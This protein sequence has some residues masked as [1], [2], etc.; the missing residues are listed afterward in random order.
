MGIYL[1][2]KTSY[3]SKSSSSCVP[4]F[5]SFGNYFP[6]GSLVLF[7][8]QI[9]SAQEPDMDSCHERVYAGW[10]CRDEVLLVNVCKSSLPCCSFSEEPHYSCWPGEERG[11]FL[12]TIPFSESGLVL[13]CLGLFWLFYLPQTLLEVDPP[14]HLIQALSKSSSQHCVKIGLPSR[15]LTPIF[16]SSPLLTPTSSS[17]H[18]RWCN[19]LPHSSWAACF[20]FMIKFSSGPKSASFLPVISVKIIW[21]DVFSTP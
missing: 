4:T 18:S 8:E 20:F 3:F 19:I 10:S 6:Q 12:S 2:E 11:V 7:S 17:L 21:R 13:V 15:C 16:V 1:N 9:S 14:S 5:Q